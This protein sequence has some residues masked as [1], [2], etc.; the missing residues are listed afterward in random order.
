VRLRSNCRALQLFAISSSFIRIL[1]LEPL[2]ALHSQPMAPARVDKHH[3][4]VLARLASKHCSGGE[5]IHVQGADCLSAQSHYARWTP[6]ARARDAHRA[7]AK[8]HNGP[9]A[10]DWNVPECEATRTAPVVLA[11][12]AVMSTPIWLRNSSLSSDTRL[13]TEAGRVGP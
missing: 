9:L 13:A 7:G 8:P 5:R 4:N 3:R 1:N 11:V 2:E 10:L 6:D 12:L